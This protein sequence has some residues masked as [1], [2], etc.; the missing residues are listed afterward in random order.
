MMSP[1]G[2]LLLFA[3]LASASAGA[4]ALYKSVDRAG[5]VTYSSTPPQGSTAE[6]LEMEPP[7]SEAE[8]RATEERLKKY[9]AQANELEAQRQHREAEEAAREAAEA[10]QR[11]AQQPEPPAET[12]TP[13]PAP[14]PDYSLPPS[15]RYPSGVPIPLTMPMPRQR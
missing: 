15:A 13:E 14:Q 4:D 5:N 9:E 2:F 6:K 12:G 10:R 3:A 7:P 1:R 8:V 11:E